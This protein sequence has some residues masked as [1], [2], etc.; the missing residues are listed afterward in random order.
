[1]SLNHDI[2]GF[3][4]GPKVSAELEIIAKQMKTLQLIRAD[5]QAMAKA[6][7]NLANPS[8]QSGPAPR[9]RS[10]PR[11]P[12][13]P[14]DA[15]GGSGGSSDTRPP[16][17]RQPRPRPAPAARDENGRFLPR[18]GSEPRKSPGS[19]NGGGGSGGNDHG[20]DDDGGKESKGS[21]HNSDALGAA[22]ESLK[23][24]AEGIK[25]GADG[26]D[27]TVTAVKELSGVMQP[28]MGA[29]KPLGRLFGRGTT[30]EKNQRESVSWYRRI[31][32]TIRDKK[33][34]GT[35]GSGGLMG[36]MLTG[37][38]SV[39]SLLLSPVRLL[40]RLIGG[41][42]GGLLKGVAA[43]G[44]GLV[45]GAGRG[46]SKVGRSLWPGS[47]GAEGESE[48]SKGGSKI[49]QGLR[50]AGKGIL[51]RIPLLGALFEGGSAIS[52]AMSADDSNLSPQENKS[53]RWGGVG[54]GI[55]GLVGGAVGMLGGPAGAMLGGVIGDK[56]GEMFG[57]WLSTID[58]SSA[59]KNAFAFIQT[60]WSGLVDTGTKA[61]GGLTDWAHDKW[62]TLTETTHA[63]KQVVA[64]TGTA[65]KNGGQNL[66][67]KVTGGSYKAGSNAARDRLVTAMDDEGMTDPKSKAALMANADHET[68]GFTR[69]E[70]NL[71]YSAKRLLEVFP[72]HYSSLADAQ[73]D[74]GNPKAIANRVYGGRMGNNAPGDGY[75][76]RGRG[77]TQ[78]TGKNNYAAIGKKLG[79]DL[80]NHPELA[81]EPRYSAQIAVAQWKASGADRAA[82]A[83]DITGARKLTNGGLNGLADVN[84]K[85]DMYLPEAQAGELTPARRADQVRVAGPSGVTGA[86]SSTMATVNGA[87]ASA[88]NGTIG[89]MAPANIPT[90][91][92]PT[93]SAPSSDAGATS[94]PAA[95]SISKPSVPPTSS[96]STPSVQVSMPLSQNMEDRSI[97]HAATGGI[98][99]GMGWLR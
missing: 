38:M 51:R 3:L 60:S 74:A 82:A 47:K 79:I 72:S 85:Y 56:L 50:G 75:N 6:L 26:I 2:D 69:N 63:A 57:S 73:A 16:A 81:S 91:Q 11:A 87:P 34:G 78:L 27:P 65:I 67:N 96:P 24:V 30:E 45:R 7:G 35:G 14:I 61:L 39:L 20:G 55:G 10:S 89:I 28:V 41:A 29:L 22:A 83:G 18:E 8:A 98:G 4:S 76:Y 25:S 66:L 43:A 71:N 88:A 13:A 53:N 99:A 84:A 86:I 93:Y 37:L 5:T 12:G 31:W 92:V 48:A 23:S 17:P 70:E 64:D 80:V 9:R 94:I 36:A 97:A 77:D 1:M 46:I 49:G 90:L 52:S 62:D 68:G 44:I 15:G 32:N 40:G 95:P 33:E 58:L 42:G 54:S 19:S 59:A 21:G